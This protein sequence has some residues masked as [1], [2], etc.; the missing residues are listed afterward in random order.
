[1]N[2][3]T[4]ITDDSSIFTTLEQVFGFNEFRPGQEEIIHAVL[5][6]RDALAIMPTGGGKSLCYQLPACMQ[7]GTSLVVSP[8]IALMK[9][10]VD[11]ANENGIRAA[12]IN[13]SQT[14]SERGEVQ[15][16]LQRGELDLVYVSPERLAAGSFMDLIRRSPVAF[17]AVDEAHCICSWGHDFRPD[18]LLLS[19]LVEE[20]PEVPIA[21][22]TASATEA[23]QLDIIQQLGLRSPFRYCGSFNRDNLFYEVALKSDPERQIVHFV[24]KN[25]GE[26]GIVYRMTRESVESTAQLLVQ[27]GISAVPY[28][29]GLGDEVRK[30]NQEEFSRDHVDVV[31][32]TIAFGMG[33]DKSN[34]RYIVHGD[35]PRSL[36]HYYQETGRAGRDGDPAHCLLLFS[37]GD[38]PRLNFFIDQVEDEQIAR[39]HR[40]ALA[41]MVHFASQHTCRR[42]NI[43]GHFGEIYPE[44][45]CG[46]CDVCT[47]EYETVDITKEA[48]ML[49]SAIAR[50][51]QRFGL[52]H[53]VNI[54]WGADTK[55]IRD[56]G[57][58]RLKTWGIGRDRSKKE[59]R[60]IGDALLAQKICVASDGRFPIVQLNS[61]SLD[62]LQGQREVSLV[63]KKLPVAWSV[64]TDEGGNREL[65][66]L[67]RQERRRFAEEQGVPPFVVFSDKTLHDMVRR[68]PK[69]SRDMLLVNG[70]GE[71]KMNQYGEAFIEVISRYAN[72]HPETVEKTGTFKLPKKPEK[73]SSSSG[74]SLTVT[75][76]RRLLEEGHSIDEIAGMRQLTTE[77]IASHCER[78]FDAGYALPIEQ[79]IATALRKAIEVIFDEHGTE[80]LKPV[81]EASEGTFGYR[82]ARIVR[83]WMRYSTEEQ[84]E[85]TG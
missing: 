35:L 31:V 54:V 53:I 43:L 57:H 27:E 9:D 76:T 83:A 44:E 33:I 18:Y 79:L 50:T 8:L 19:R 67:L 26:P 65:F 13:S 24:K 38:I 22:F 49:L 56:F 72:E 16:A 39:Q 1:M 42:R 68:M 6:R 23:M 37:R 77:T 78:L 40:A 5:S 62:V 14:E 10:Q 30:K 41:D 82:E 4:S 69:N 63:Q 64:K 2:D 29:A 60:E 71:R 46:K 66:E 59:W 34:V 81:V 25:R 70:V 28:H 7:Q 20:L 55:Q 61:A 17:V 11:A 51:G 48:Q 36:E 3:R 73:P 75:E 74:I 80:R 85:K 32:A 45:K 52:N 21:A 12:F 47:G 84:A 15:G 58:D